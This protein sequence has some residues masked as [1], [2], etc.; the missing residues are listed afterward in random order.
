M[1]SPEVKKVELARGSIDRILSQDHGARL[2][3]VALHRAQAHVAANPPPNSDP[4]GSARGGSSS[5]VELDERDEDRMVSKDAQW[6]VTNAPKMVAQAAKILFDLERASIRMLAT[7]DHSKLPAPKEI[8]CT[9]CARKD[10]EGRSDIG[11]HYAAVY[12]KAKKHGLCRFCWEH[13]EWDKGHL[14]VTRLP[15]VKACE[16]YHTQGPRAAGVWL[17][18]QVAA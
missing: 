11:G 3:E 17:A 12:D 6:F 16:L 10:R 15:P 9:S 5:P 4:K 2:L 18:K 14:N 13:A 8:A 1:S 7:I